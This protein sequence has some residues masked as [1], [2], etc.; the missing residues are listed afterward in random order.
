MDNI[1]NINKS[2]QIVD[3]F[4]QIYDK[5]NKNKY[6]QNIKILND[7]L[8]KLYLIFYKEYN[9]SLRDL[10]YLKEEKKIFIQKRIVL[11]NK[12]MT[13]KK[14]IMF[15]KESSYPWPWIE[16]DNVDIN[17]RFINK[18]SME[19]KELKYVNEKSIKTFYCNL[20]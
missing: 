18:K 3:E 14:K 13:L 2:I 20:D 11:I 1:N 10:D 19:L 12:L 9:L 8:Y 7:K 15:L 5:L 17:I 4:E 16:L 6:D